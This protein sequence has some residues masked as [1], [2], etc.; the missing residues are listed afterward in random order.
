[1]SPLPLG[2]INRRKRNSARRHLAPI[3]AVATLFAQSALAE[4]ISSM[5]LAR[6]D[7]LAN[8]SLES[9]MNIDVV[10]V[11][12]R[13]EPLQRS[14]AAVFVLDSSSIIRSGVK[15][16]PEALRLIP[17]LQVAR[18]DS[19]S[20]AVTARG[21]N[22]SAGADKLEVLMDGRSL[23]SPVYSGV[24]WDAQDTLIEDIA[25][26]EVIRGPG[27]SLWGS[28]AVNGV[29]N[30]VTKT[31]A[32]TQGGFEQLGGGGEFEGFSSFRYGGKLGEKGHYRLYAKTIH[33]AAQEIAAPGDAADSSKS[34][35]V[36]FRTDL[37]L[38]EIDSLT[39]QGD[40][41]RGTAANPN[42]SKDEFTSGYNLIS[43]WSRRYDDNS[44]TELQLYYDQTS[45]NNRINFAEDRNTF[46]VEIKHRFALGERQN[47]VLGG[48]YRST[49]DDIEDVN[50]FLVK[51]IPSS[52]KDETLDIFAQ[53]QIDLIENILHLTLGAKFEK[54]DYTGA[55]FQPSARLSY[56]FNQ[57]NTFWGAVSRAVRIPNR[58]DHTV[59]LF[60]GQIT[61][62]DHFTA[63]EV[64]AY[65]MGYRAILT[66]QLSTDLAIFYNEYDKLRTF[67]DDF[68]NPQNQQI[69]FDNQGA[70]RTQGLELTLRWNPLPDLQLLASYNYFDMDISAK[71]GSRD[72]FIN[73]NNEND[74][75][76]QVSLRI[77]W[78][79][80]ETWSIQARGRWIDSIDDAGVAS[81]SAIDI[82]G[83]W[84]LSTSID[85][86]LV[87][88]NLFD[89]QHAEFSGGKEIVRSIHGQFTWHF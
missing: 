30:I 12:K 75:S 13:S 40:L 74:P 66:T 41:H 18:V 71:Y 67:T 55:E 70:G 82:S 48:G 57:R 45:R 34:N 58:I 65:E 17:G 25:R 33:N 15:N 23:Y 60:N 7:D 84:R 35:Q 69:H 68:T 53:D 61:G 47:F 51:F 43:R 22:A 19:N 32:E 11:S 78:D 83:T 9:L 79:A 29:V 76:S 16:I 81:Y 62:D 89:P 73:R 39:I 20:W 59:S 64:V 44:D 24:F 50:P 86:S 28:N 26:I 63:E 4:S 14:P 80:S 49:E 54:N 8:L 37:K 2:S 46:D 31:A 1:M 27:A 56:I 77:D 10:S 3:I 6:V 52:R 88:T 72:I 36:G 42:T 21:F 5:Q 85:I 38:N 87:G